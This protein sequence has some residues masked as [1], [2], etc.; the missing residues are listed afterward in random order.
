MALTSGIWAVR[1]VIILLTAGGCTDTFFDYESA[2]EID[3]FNA[4]MSLAVLGAYAY[5][6]ACKYRIVG[7]YVRA[8]LLILLAFVWLSFNLTWSYT[9]YLQ[10]HQFSRLDVT[11]AMPTSILM[12]IETILTL[13]TEARRK[14]REELLQSCHQQETMMTAARGEHGERE[15]AGGFGMGATFW[16]IRPLPQDEQDNVE[17]IIPVSLQ[18][19]PPSRI[20]T[21]PDCRSAISSATSG[22]GGDDTQD[23]DQG[24]V[25]STNKSAM[26]QRPAQVYFPTASGPSSS[27]G[28]SS[29]SGRGQLAPT[30]GNNLGDDQ[31]PPYSRH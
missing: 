31:L 2:Y 18:Y 9:R 22:S 19:P 26:Y 29:S 1:V 16:P 25:Q 23:S 7:I 20:V 17:V 15:G 4:Y 28:P 14:R 11:I 21:G 10:G 3:R 8:A 12:V 30:S 13:K 24:S 5:A 27:A 6:L